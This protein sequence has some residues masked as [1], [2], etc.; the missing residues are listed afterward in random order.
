VRAQ[1]LT[2]RSGDGNATRSRVRASFIDFGGCGLGTGVGWWWALLL[3]AAQPIGERAARFRLCQ[4]AFQFPPAR[5]SLLRHIS[6]PPAVASHNTC[7]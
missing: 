3:L 6:S 1:E 2:A 5:F 7:S 4:S